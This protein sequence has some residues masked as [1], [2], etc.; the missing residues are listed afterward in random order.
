MYKNIPGS[1]V[2]E[3][4]KNDSGK[5]CLIRSWK[6]TKEKCNFW[7]NGMHPWNSITY[8]QCFER[9]LKR[10]DFDFRAF[11]PVNQIL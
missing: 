10:S 4:K 9:F 1:Q 3:I 8:L 5:C 11:L 6:M 7:L 2:P